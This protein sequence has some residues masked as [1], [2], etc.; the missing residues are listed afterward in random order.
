MPL[1]VFSGVAEAPC[2]QS[3]DC[4]TILFEAQAHVGLNLVLPT[5]TVRHLQIRALLWRSEH[6][7]RRQVAGNR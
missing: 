6:Q 5:A 2:L 3:G 1:A 7:H 4:P